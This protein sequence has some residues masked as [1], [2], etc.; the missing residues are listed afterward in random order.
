MA[1][2]P[3]EVLLPVDFEDR[4]TVEELLTEA[5]PSHGRT[6][7][8]GATSCGWSSWRTRT[9]VTCSRSGRC[10]AT[11]ETRADDVL[12]DLQDAL[13]LK[14]VPRL[15]ACFDISHTQGTEVVGSASS[16]ATASRTRAS[17]GASASGAT[18]ATTTS[19]PW[20]R[21]SAATFERRL[22]GSRSRCRS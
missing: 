13:E 15:I 22:D 11:I 17:T 9:H 2:L 3:R 10:W 1:D 19:A 18:G 7:R 12:Y 14:V 6:S 21:W 16:S 4:P 8:C 20:R 5:G